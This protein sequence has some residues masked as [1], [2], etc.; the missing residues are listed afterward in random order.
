L[1]IRL[2]IE[3]IYVYNILLITGNITM[4]KYKDLEQYP[5]KDMIED[6]RDTKK[7]GDKLHLQFFAHSL[8]YISK[9]VVLVNCA[10]LPFQGEPGEMISST[11]TYE[12]MKNDFLA[13]RI[14]K[15]W[16]DVPRSKLI[17]VALTHKDARQYSSVVPLFMSAFKLYDD[18]GYEKWDKS[19]KMLKY[20]LGKSLEGLTDLPEGWT[21]PDDTMQERVL[22]QTYSTGTK[23]GET[24]P[25]TSYKLNRAT[26]YAEGVAHNDIIAR[27]VLQTWL[28]N[29]IY[30]ND[31]MILDPWDWDSMPEAI[32][33]TTEDILSIGTT[34]KKGSDA[35][36][37]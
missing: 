14:L 12:K 33:I 35:L 7:V 22:L 23:S 25:P 3:V 21:G 27:M 8:A 2:D 16:Y 24:E 15:L 4:Y 31:L 26:W 32:D 17:A 28:F 11:N 29:T 34:S 37:Y 30:R 10:N 5:L 6:W 20:F 18:V 36:D 13:L 1:K 9:N 19:D